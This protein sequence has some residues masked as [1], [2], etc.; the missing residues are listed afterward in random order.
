MQWI[1]KEI[2]RFPASDPGP[3][4]IHVGVMYPNT[5]PVSVSSLGFQT[6]HRLVHSHPGIVAHRIILETDGGKNYPSR[7]LLEGLE[8][9]SLDAI[10]IS[11]SFELDYLN[12]VRILDA[13]R[14][15]VLRKN[16]GGLPLILIGGIAPTANPE[17]LAEIADA[18][19]IGKAEVNLPP[20]L[21]DLLEI[22]PLLTG[23]R[24]KSG[25]DRLYEMWDR[26][27]GIYV[28]ALWSNE[29]G[30]FSGRDGQVITQAD[31]HDLD[32]F[33]SY[34]PIISPG[35]VYGS[36]NLVEISTGC[37][38]HCRFCLL[39]YI[40]PP[41]PGRSLE[42]I[43]ENARIFKPDEASVGLI[44]SRVSDHPDIVK[45]INSLSDDGYGVSVSSL[46]VS[47]TSR[48]LLEALARS[49]ART[50]TF[51][52][53]HGSEKI[54][55][56]ISK[57]YSY[58]DVL[59][60]TRW[61]YEAGMNRVKLYFLTGFDEE[62][63]SDLDATIDYITHI[64]EDTGL[65]DIGMECRLII[66]IAP[67]VPKAST[68]FQRRRMQ[69]ERTLKQKMKRVTG[70]LKILP[71]VEIETE[72]PRSSIVQGLLSIAD[73]TVT[74]HLVEFSKSRGPI[75]S[76][77]EEIVRSIP[78]NPTLNVHETRNNSTILPWGFIKRPNIKADK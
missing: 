4:P 68:A 70:A 7:T 55:E 65:R 63:D 67:F 60:R 35:G 42:S 3:D 23:K 57:K 54:L 36:K 1:D 48:E 8:I 34:T 43:L 22:H 6:V 59:Q 29:R 9:K 33:K 37:P 31:I 75:L 69:D 77:W 11:C 78:E 72:S 38:S 40:Y 74:P 28:P 20:A 56:I 44:S 58:D 61:A 19:F 5:Y 53:E 76:T 47:S 46:K 18:I 45:V 49:G 39:S 64:A 51:A 17:P 41:G 10:A 32:E 15:P 16:R 2:R 12:L 71:K 62:T 25:R 13:S 14:I 52:P 24:F 21:D 50:V 66:G 26:H 27:D 30:E 73:R